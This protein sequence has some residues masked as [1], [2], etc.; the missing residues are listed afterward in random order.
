MTRIYPL[1]FFLLFLLPVANMAQCTFTHTVSV[2][3]PIL[4]NGDSNGQITANVT[5]TGP[6]TFLWSNGQTTQTATGLPPGCYT[7]TMTDGLSCSTDTVVC[8]FQPGPLNVFTSTNPDNCSQCV[9]SAGSLAGGGTAPYSYLWS[10]AAS[11]QSTTGLCA[12]NYMI[13]VTDNNGCTVSDTV[14]VLDIPGPVCSAYVTTPASCSTCPD[15]VLDVSATGGNGPYTYTWNPSTQNTATAT[16]LITGN[17]TVTITDA[18]GCT[19]TD[20][21]FLPFTVGIESI[22]NPENPT[23]IEVFLHDGRQIFEGLTMPDLP[24][25]IYLIRYRFVNGHKVKKLVVKPS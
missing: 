9:G 4:C 20:T 3:S 10:N 13:T 11:S 21:I 19:C 5:G 15:G 17:Y 14:T 12:G 24:D 16:G 6:F 1:L 22:Q 25:G 2:S 8:I 18:N 7:V 23:S